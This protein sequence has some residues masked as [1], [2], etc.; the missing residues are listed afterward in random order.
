LRNFF[1]IPLKR[2]SL[3]F[4]TTYFGL[5][6]TLAISATVMWLYNSRI[7]ASNNKVN[8]EFFLAQGTSTVFVA[9]SVFILATLAC[10]YV[11]YW[12]RFKCL[13]LLLNRMHCNI[14][15]CIKTLHLF[16]EIHIYVDCISL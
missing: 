7:N 14:Y 5:Y 2:K 16:F 15:R 1:L 11:S 9:S 10:M 12:N 13:Q 6:Y 3:I 4:S 8:P